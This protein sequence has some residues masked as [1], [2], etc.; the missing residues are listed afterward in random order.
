MTER[1]EVKT[2]TTIKIFKNR[3]GHGYD[4][5]VQ[6]DNGSDMTFGVEDYGVSYNNQVY[7]VEYKLNGVYKT[8]TCDVCTDYTGESFN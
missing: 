2:M 3:A 5:T 7:T 1:T 4:M 6:A 8:V